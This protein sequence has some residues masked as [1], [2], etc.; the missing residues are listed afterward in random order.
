MIKQIQLRGISRTPSDRAT[1]DGGLAESL[2]IYLDS[3]EN[4]PAL[5]P[6]DVTADLGLPADLEADRIFIHKTANYENYIVV[7]NDRVVAYTPQIE[8]KEPLLILE[9]NEGEAVRN[10][11]SL[12]NTIVIATQRSS[13]YA[14]YRAGKYDYLGTQIPFP[15]IDAKAELTYEL[16]GY[17]DP[18]TSKLYCKYNHYLDGTIQGDKS[19]L[20]L[21]MVSLPFDF[22]NWDD[23]NIDTET[24]NNKGWRK[25]NEAIKSEV[26]YWQGI[27]DDNQIFL[28]QIF[29]R[30]GVELYDGSVIYCLP[31]LLPGGFENA[32]G[33][34]YDKD[35]QRIRK[36]SPFKIVQESIEEEVTIYALSPYKVRVNMSQLDENLSDWQDVINSINIYI[37]KEM[38]LSPNNLSCIKGYHS[39][40]PVYI[41]VENTDAEVGQTLFMT[42]TQINN[43]DL[44]LYWGNRQY[45]TEYESRLL[46]KSSFYLMEKVE[47]FSKKDKERLEELT[48]GTYL[49]TDNYFKDKAAF[50]AAGPENNG[51]Q[52]EEVFFDKAYQYNNSLIAH[53]VQSIV[54]SKGMIPLPRV[55]ISELDIDA[56]YP[57]RHPTTYSTLENI[58]MFFHLEDMGQGKVVAWRNFDGEVA[59]SDALSSYYQFIL[60]PDANCTKVDIY[61]LGQNVKKTTLAMRRHPFLP[62]MSYCY[63]SNLIDVTS[64]LRDN[65]S[66]NEITGLVSLDNPIKNIE[67]KL[68]VSKTDSVFL[69]PLERRYTFQSKVLGVAVATTALSQGQYGQF[70][71]YVFTE[72]GIWAM[73]TGDDGSFTS[74]KPLSRDVCVNPD[75]IT[76]IDNGVVFV[77]SKGVMMISGSQVTNLSPNMNGKHYVLDENTEGKLANTKWSDLILAMKDPDPFMSF[78]K[79]ARCAYDYEGNRL[80][81]LSPSNQGFQYVYKLD[82]R[83]W[84]KFSMG[85]NLRQP[86]NSYPECL[87]QGVQTIDNPDASDTYIEC[88]THLESVSDS[89]IDSVFQDMTDGVKA[90][91]ALT[92]PNL[93]DKNNYAKFIT[94]DI[95]KV[96]VN[97]DEAIADPI[98]DHIDYWWSHRGVSAGYV[99]IPA[100]ID[101][102]RILDLSTILDVANPQAPA[103]GCIITRPIDLGEVDIKKT[104]K[105]IRIRG[106]Y[107]KGHVSFIL[108]G[109]DDGFN[110]SILNSLR[111]KSWKLF[112]MIILTDLQPHERISWIDIEYE[113]RFKNRMR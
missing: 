4:A 77:T 82:T 108:Q 60:F 103:K 73:E 99:Y 15:K 50:I 95:K 88:I 38:E 44:D 61:A 18:F 106:Q 41:E 22:E 54:Q 72:D 105:D 10:I 76:S 113:T 24:A 2:N 90:K 39:S 42:T 110:W 11:N 40:L 111:G 37:S 8:D 92:E 84:H 68:F 96:K 13:H 32:F 69:F 58:Y 1:E 74:Q 75:S 98:I 63:Q 87:V 30:Y 25:L 66:E 59:L 83:T 33:V 107:E 85:L 97:G 62:N 12:G 36:N 67:N 94:G 7:Q 46:D 104:I 100:E 21:D 45:M 93:S 48:Q 34:H 23:A 14:L 78:M 70:P 89:D 43:S 27:A 55:T 56:K 35:H 47:L 64:A 57:L 80:I 16:K 71:L 6:D 26:D 28:N 52:Y 49:K 20:L 101:V 81:F 3:D 53:S 102:V 5:I 31:Y 19:R 109:S 17:K 91:L 65:A 29:I 112:R 9:L 79:D 51:L 86:L